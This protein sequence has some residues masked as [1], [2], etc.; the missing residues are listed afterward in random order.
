MDMLVWTGV[1][2]RLAG[3]S[4]TNSLMQGSATKFG[5]TGLRKTSPDRTPTPAHCLGS[6]TSAGWWGTAHQLSLTS[7]DLVTHA[8]GE[9]V[10][11]HLGGRHELEVQEPQLHK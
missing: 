3:R 5:M 10:R 9:A 6:V 1:G 11:L 8:L 4:M 7:E 2:D